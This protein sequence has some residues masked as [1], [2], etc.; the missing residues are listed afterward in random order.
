MTNIEV[1]HRA[2]ATRG[3]LRS[4]GRHMP[5]LSVVSLFADRGTEVGL[6]AIGRLEAVFE[7]QL[8]ERLVFRATSGSE[9][10]VQPDRELPSSG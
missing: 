7:E 6:D 8:D 3:R 9:E 10:C 5:P 4:N 2:P 1:L